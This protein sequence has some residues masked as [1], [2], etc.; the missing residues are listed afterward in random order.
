VSRRTAAQPVKFLLVGAAGYGLNLLV[1]AGLHEA[2]VPYA[3]ASVAAYLI[4]NAFMYAGN[5]YFTFGLGHD[6]FWRGYLRY[7]L[8]GLVVAALTAS[9]L[10]LLVEVAGL[11]PTPGQALALLV[12]TPVAFGLIKRWTFQL[13]PSVSA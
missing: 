11:P 3:A 1:F 2:S 5:R 12:V 6:G 4:A 13:G 8:V 9:I 10:A 7:L